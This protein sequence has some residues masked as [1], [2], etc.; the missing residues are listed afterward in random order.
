[1]AVLGLAERR[2]KT[3]ILLELDC[4][5][6][7][8]A[9]IEL[10]WRTLGK[11][12]VRCLPRLHAKTFIA[13]NEVLIGSANASANGLGAE[14]NEAKH[15]HELILLSHDPIAVDEARNWFSQKAPYYIQ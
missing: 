1:M 7:N 8:P 15:W 10:L 3:L 13:A 2:A 6:S 14:G 11:E 4:G 5:G 9:E 12:R